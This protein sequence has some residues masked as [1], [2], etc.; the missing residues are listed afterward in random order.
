MDTK[1]KPA[2]APVLPAATK[3]C[4]RKQAA[5]SAAPPSPAKKPARKQARKEG[6]TVG[7]D[8]VFKGR[9]AKIRQRAPPK[10]KQTPVN[11]VESESGSGSAPHG[12]DLSKAGQRDDEQD[13]FLR[14]HD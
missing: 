6:T 2:A 8:M 1:K 7:V 12:V 10:P 11:V 3:K 4:T 5:L 14:N 9:V 13:V